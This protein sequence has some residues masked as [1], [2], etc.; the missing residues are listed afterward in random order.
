MQTTVKEALAKAT[1]DAQE[2]LK[3]TTDGDGNVVYDKEALVTARTSLLAAIGDANTS[4]A[5]YTAL[6]SRIDYA[7]KVLGWWKD[8]TRK[9]TAVGKLQEAIATAEDKVKDYTLTTSQLTSAKTT[10]NSKISSVDK[11]IYCSGNACGSD[12]DLQNPDNQWCYDRSLQSKHW[13]LFWEEGYGKSTPSSVE[14]ILNT[15]DKIFEFYAD[16][17]KYIT[18]NQGKSKTDTYKMIIRLRYTTDW[19][20]SGSGIDNVIGLLTLSRW[21]YTSREGQTVAHEIGHCFQY[22]TH[23]DN[24][25]QNGWMYTWANSGNGNVFWE[26]CAQWQAYKYYPAMQFNNEWLNNTLNGLHKNPLAEE[27]RLQQLLHTGLL[28]SQA[29][30]GC[31]RQSLEQVAE[32]RGSFPG[33][34][35]HL[36][37][38]QDVE[39]TEVG[40][41]Q[42]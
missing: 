18:I 3:G 41:V 6:Q 27:S 29:W 17:L 11:H 21:A 38:L 31:P 13:I 24:N 26:M 19:E 35:A 30:H 9:A 10:L 16:S 15:A 42:Q 23:C 33:L 8:D 28:L 2:A 40:A 12:A 5:L 39:R 36:H 4:K 25:N 20:A 1:A 34:H 22:Q 7:E 37:G 14:T 32:P